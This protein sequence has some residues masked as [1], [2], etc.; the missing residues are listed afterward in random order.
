MIK[1]NFQAL[2]RKIFLFR[3]IQ[4]LATFWLV[5]IG[6]FTETFGI[7]LIKYIFVLAS[8]ICIPEVH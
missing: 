3:N 1:I 2:L 5:C 8:F 4:S 7:D 6:Q